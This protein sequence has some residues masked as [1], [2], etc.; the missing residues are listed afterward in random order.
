MVTALH[1]LAL[2]LY[3]GAAAVLTGSL[4]EGRRHAPVAG[5]LLAG[6]GLLVHG[7]ALAAFFLR[8]GE[9]PLVGLAPS[10]STFAFLIAL[11]LLISTALPAV[12]PIGLVLLPLAVV[13]I[14]VAL[15]L[16]IRPA[17][18]AQA[19]RGIWFSLHI[20]LAFIGFAGLSL[21]FASGLLYLLQF[22]QLKQKQFG[23]MFRFFPPLETLDVV[24]RWA[25]AAGFPAL[26]AA[27]LLGAAWTVRFQAPISVPKIAWAVASWVVFA[28]IVGVRL[29]GAGAERRGAVAVVTGF[30]VVTVLYLVLR[31]SAASSGVFL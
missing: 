22:R 7:G 25:I 4:A 10:L 13:M 1:V 26:T 5:A 29:G 12:R 17:A 14:G 30:V 2:L 28:I 18:E 11:F 6:A 8:F 31:L 23:R 24:E 21:A 9:A 19:Y 20:L 27:L 16:G 15:A 3:G